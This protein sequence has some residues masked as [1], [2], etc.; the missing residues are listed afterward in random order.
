MRDRA[1]AY[2]VLR[3][4][5]RR[6]FSFPHVERKVFDMERK[7]LAMEAILDIL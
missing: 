4:T 2:R 6:R 5:S 3:R 7:N 1:R